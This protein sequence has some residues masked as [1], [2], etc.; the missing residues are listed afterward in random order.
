MPAYNNSPFQPPVIALQP[1]KTEFSWGG[2]D[3][4]SSPTKMLVSNV[5]LTSNVATLTVQMT[6]GPVP[7]V[8]SLIYVQ[9]TQSTAGLF[10]V[11]GV[12]LASVTINST[13]G[14]GTLT[15]ALTH[16]NVTSAADAGQAIV[17]T[18][19][20]YEA[21]GSA[22][23]GRQF[24]IPHVAFVGGVRNLSWFTAF[25]GSPATVTMNLQIADEDID[26]QY[27]TVDTSSVATGETREVAK[28]PI[29]MIAGKFVRVQAASTGGTSPTVRAGI[30]LS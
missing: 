26:A 13:T 7:A 16:A 4:L 20:T 25:T 22:A 10:N 23:A 8:G 1:G 15:F 6:A 21:I 2:F 27:T 29:N 24:A 17:Q 9:G 11:S 30:V 28:V 14:A 18:P 19:P 3:A 5:A 12:A